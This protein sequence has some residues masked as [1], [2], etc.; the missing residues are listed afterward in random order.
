MEPASDKTVRPPE[1]TAYC[2][3]SWCRRPAQC[4]SPTGQRRLCRS[5][6]P[7]LKSVQ[8]KSLRRSW[9]ANYSQRDPCSKLKMHKSRRYNPS[10]PSPAGNFVGI[11]GTP[12]FRAL[13]H[14]ISDSAFPSCTNPEKFFAYFHRSPKR[15]LRILPPEHWRSSS[16][17]FSA[18]FCNNFPWAH[19]SPLRWRR[20]WYKAE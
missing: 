1:R 7:P 3:P 16:P 15:P 5:D 20:S 9:R 12:I 2:S 11:R 13:R 18:L 10:R 4:Q 6:F 19:W 8:G 17:R 14:N